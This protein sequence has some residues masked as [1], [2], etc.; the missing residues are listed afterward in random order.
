MN[1]ARKIV[2]AACSALALILPGPAAGQQQRVWADAPFKERAIL[3]GDVDSSLLNPLLFDAGQG[4]AAV[5]DY[6]DYAVKA[7][8][9]EMGDVV[10]QQGQRGQGPW[11]FDNP[12]DLVVGK[13]D[14]VWVL[15]PA[16]R[17]ISV[18]G[19]DGSQGRTIRADQESYHRFALSRDGFYAARSEVQLGLVAKL[20]PDLALVGDMAVPPWV[21]EL[22]YFSSELRMGGAPNGSLV[23]VAFRY[24]GRILLNSGDE[25]SLREVVA[26]ATAD[27]PEE[28][29]L[30]LPG[31]GV[32]RRLA[33]DT[34][35]LVREVAV[36]GNDVYVLSLDESDE[37]EWS[38]NVV[39][40]YA[41][42][43]GY[44]HS[45]RLN[46]PASGIAVRNGRVVLLETDLLPRITEIQIERNNLD[47][48]ESSR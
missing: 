8:S 20:A 19:P 6:G 42:D 26:V 10:W 13:A 4:I 35:S 46:R 7:V 3:D 21:P 40:V 1:A 48:P 2:L 24:T 39:D 17:R 38:S 29:V 5:F 12:M 25:M 41:A 22:T 14:S 47:R 16:N 11:E 28:I 44:R 32:A 45:L 36:D 23:V 33:P 30:T 34:R 9:L 43:T 27:E 31:G 18:F 37:D 15:D